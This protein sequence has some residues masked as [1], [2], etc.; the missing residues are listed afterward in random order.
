MLPHGRVLRIAPTSAPPRAC[1]P[2]PD[3]TRF[4]RASRSTPGA[5]RPRSCR[6]RW[7][8][9][10][11]SPDRPSGTRSRA[12]S[13]TSAPRSRRCSRSAPCHPALT[14]AVEMPGRTLQSFRIRPSHTPA[15]VRRERTTG[16]ARCMCSS[17]MAPAARLS[18]GR[19][20]PPAAAS[21]SA[22]SPRRFRSRPAVCHPA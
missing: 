10:R 8:T 1:R 18:T 12:P 19:P 17:R 7:C 20:R 3:P 16:V 5:S 2:A 13:A 22:G 21:R 6:L 9:S 4:R 14:P 15:I 11:P